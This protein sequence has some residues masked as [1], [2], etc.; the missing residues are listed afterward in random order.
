MSLYAA[1]RATSAD[2]RRREARKAIGTA[3][4]AGNRLTVHFR[5][6]S[7]RGDDADARYEA[8]EQ[9]AHA[10]VEKADAAQLG[11]YHVAIPGSPGR[12]EIIAERIRRLQEIQDRL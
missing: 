11:R 8:F 12:T 6:E 7:R 3:I 10:A 9:A 2:R 4:D 1:W 5:A